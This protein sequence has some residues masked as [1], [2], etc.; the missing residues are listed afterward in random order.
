[1]VA[2][3]HTTYTWDPVTAAWVHERGPQITPPPRPPDVHALQSYFFDQDSKEWIRTV[4]APMGRDL[5]ARYQGAHKIPHGGSEKT[6]GAKTAKAKDATGETKKRGN[7]FVALVVVVLLVLLGGVGV[8]ASQSG[9]LAD[10]SGALKTT[11]PETVAPG[12]TAAPATAVPSANGTAAASTP[13]TAAPAP[14]TAPAPTAAPPVVTA[15]PVAIPPGPN[16]TLGDGTVV[17]YTGP[18]TATRGGFLPA[19]FTVIA[20][21][22][23][24]AS[25]EITIVLGDLTKDPRIVSGTLDANGKIALDVP[26]TL[27]VGQYP[28]SVVYKGSRATLA[29]ITLR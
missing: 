8:V 15:R 13:A 19:S 21:N 22:G 16:A 9:L 14:T 4:L 26:A 5:A 24:P 25:G 12:V 18:L 10:N 1:M 20:P 23:R 11:A 29:T 27:A 2:V 17:V 3:E 28:L 7:T 6:K